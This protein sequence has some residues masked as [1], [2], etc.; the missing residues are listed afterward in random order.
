MAAIVGIEGCVAKIEGIE[1][2]FILYKHI[3]SERI[4]FLGWA[5]SSKLVFHSPSG[6]AHKKIHETLINRTE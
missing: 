5:C 4:K 3:S 1:N 2:C 6:D